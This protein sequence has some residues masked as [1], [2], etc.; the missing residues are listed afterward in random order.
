M[1]PWIRSLSIVGLCLGQ[2]AFVETGIVAEGTENE[3]SEAWEG[4]EVE[5]PTDD[6]DPPPAESVPDQASDAAQSGSCPQIYDNG[7]LDETSDDYRFKSNSVDSNGNQTCV[8]TRDTSRDVDGLPKDNLYLW[9]CLSLILL[10]IGCGNGKD[11][12]FVHKNNQMTFERPY[13]TYLEETIP[14]C[15]PVHP[16]EKT[17]CISTPFDNFG[18]FASSASGPIWAITGGIPSLVDTLLGDG[19]PGLVPHIVI[20]GGVLK[21]STRCGLYPY[22]KFPFHTEGSTYKNI[23]YYSC[24]V[25][26]K[27]HEY[28]VGVSPPLITAIVHFEPI[29]LTTDQVERWSQ[30]KQE[31]LKELGDPQTKTATAFEGREFVWF[32][33]PSYTMSVETWVADKT[34]TSFWLVQQ[35][36][37]E[38]RVVSPDI[39]WADTA[40]EQAVLDMPLDDLVAKIKAADIERRKLTDGR[41][42]IT[43][44]DDDSSDTEGGDHMTLPLLVT[45]ANKLQDYYVAAG[46]VYEGENKTT[47]L[48]PPPPDDFVP[49]ST[50]VASSTTSSSVPPSS[51]TSVGLTSTTAVESST[52][53]TPESSTTTRVR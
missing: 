34:S 47:V 49:P 43:T 44:V 7:T 20:R 14:P 6:H 39:V 9:K 40:E 16:S 25:E 19:Y 37:G 11:N 27:V 36:E 41:V 53:T 32:L 15:T 24:L 45:D 2:V 10:I 28:I 42:G 46:A 50:T 22:K 3:G 35:R 38:V 5:D 17:F 1:R 8:Y 13:P 12:S 26:I 31:I 33:L 52:T 48:P 29:G 18:S 4:V 23:Y 21:D 30:I 51:S